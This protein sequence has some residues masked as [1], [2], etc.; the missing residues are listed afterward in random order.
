M[1]IMYDLKKIGERIQSERITADLSKVELAKE[2]GCSRQLIAKW[3]KGDG[4]L[5]LNEMLA[6]CNLFDCELGYLLCE[7]DCKT[8]TATDIH[9]ETGLSEDAV[10]KLH[11]WTNPP[12]NQE[13]L[14]FLSRAHINFLNEIIPRLLPTVAND[15]LSLQTQRDS[16]TKPSPRTEN[17][18]AEFIKDS[19]WFTEKYPDHPILSGPT[20][21]V[22]HFAREIARSI[23]S[24]LRG[25]TE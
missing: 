5:F 19:R 11:E 2:V 17:D 6:M 3:E 21:G 12:F 20:A 10:N 13:N 8:R 1:P 15:Y 9:E 23:E 25:D 7:Y 4:T 18:V 16:F 24:I 14:T 22:Q